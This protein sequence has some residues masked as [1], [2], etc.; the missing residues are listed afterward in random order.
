MK[1]L[2]LDIVAEHPDEPGGADPE[3]GP[4][5]AE[6]KDGL[7][8]GEHVDVPDGAKPEDVP[9]CAEPEDRTVGEDSEAG[10]VV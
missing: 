10:P 2:R 8:G 7:V 6:S 4:V 5:D 9:V 3:V 1:K